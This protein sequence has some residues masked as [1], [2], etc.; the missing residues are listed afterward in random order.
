MGVESSN[1]LPLWIDYLPLGYY[2]L[3]IQILGIKLENLGPILAQRKINNID[4][5]NILLLSPRN[6]F[7]SGVA[8]RVSLT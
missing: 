2:F 7:G 4:L 6:S 8:F 3:L 5:N 1:I